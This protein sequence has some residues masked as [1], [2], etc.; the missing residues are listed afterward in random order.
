MH[1]SIGAY[2]ELTTSTPL[3]VFSS[4][5]AAILPMQA[6]NANGKRD[7]VPAD[8]PCNVN[9]ESFDHV[10]VPTSA[11]LAWRDA[12][13]LLFSISLC[14][15]LKHLHLDGVEVPIPELPIA[16]EKFAE[17]LSGVSR[18]DSFRSWSVK[19]SSS[20]SS[21]VELSL[22]LLSPTALSSVQT[23]VV[24]T[25]TDASGLATSIPSLASLQ[26]LDISAWVDWSSH[27]PLVDALVSIQARLRTIYLK[28]G[29]ADAV[30]IYRA[31]R[32]GKHVGSL[33]E[34]PANRVQDSHGRLENVITGSLSAR[35]RG[36]G[37]IWP[38]SKMWEALGTQGQGV[39]IAILDSGVSQFH[40]GLRERIKGTWSF[41]PLLH[42]WEDVNGHGTHVAGIIAGKTANNEPMGVAPLA[43]LYV[44]RICDNDGRISLSATVSGI[45]WAVAQGCDIINMSF[46]CKDDPSLYTAVQ[47]ALA[48]N[49]IIVCAATNFGGLYRNSIA[50][51][52]RYG[53]VICVGNH[54]RDGRPA[55]SSAS[56]RE[57]DFLAPGTDIFSCVSLSGGYG[58]LS[59]T[60]MAAPFVTG[61]VALLLASNVSLRSTLNCSVIRQVL[62]AMCTSP[63]HHDQVQ[64]HGVL[65]PMLILRHRN[66]CI[67]EALKQMNSGD[68]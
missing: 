40:P 7:R 37:S 45:N 19:P 55:G 52:A 66:A 54:D 39:K 2:V 16:S 41:V 36:D 27:R 46:G 22:Q 68:E 51:P 57:V 42:A 67:A 33:Q 8:V 49:V 25:F 53:N 1:A 56:G 21:C 13:E 32:C 17:A 34:L 30:A 44:G 6:D 38:L 60:S 59:R 48:A 26:E 29:G 50:Y 63:G 5:L 11:P 3:Y 12:L 10:I 62:R 43:D 61:L 28:L 35:P 47:R 15:H 23:L 65:N 18:V 20:Y 4:R 14:S 64:G 58:M 9:V 24:N 31:I